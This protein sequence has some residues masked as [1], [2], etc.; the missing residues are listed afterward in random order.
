MRLVCFTDHAEQRFA[1]RLT[2]DHPGG[3]ENL[4][5]AVLGIGLREHHQ[6]DVGR[7]ALRLEEQIG[8]VI[9]FVLRQGQAQP[10]VRRDQFSTTA[11]QQIDAGQRFWSEVAEQIRR[12]RKAV[13]HGFQHAIMQQR[14]DAGPLGRRE[15]AL[16]VI[17]PEG[18][19]AFNTFDC[20]QAAV[21]GDVAC[22][23]RPR[24]D[25]SDARCDEEQFAALAFARGALFE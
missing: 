15:S 13:E 23:R 25:R 18:N 11:A 22:L 17:E 3:V 1:A 19:A 8:E 21:A 5:P 4:V 7:V 12:A 6:L 16:P 24:R 14:G 2:V 9:D 10:P 20:L